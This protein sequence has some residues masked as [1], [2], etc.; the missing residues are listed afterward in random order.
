[1]T[2]DQS[3]ITFFI[4]RCLGNSVAEA[5]RN[6]GIAIEVHRDHFPD[7]TLDI[8]WIPEVARRNWVVL[9]KDSNIGKNHLERNAVARTG[10]K[11]FTL[12]SANLSGQKMSEIFLKAIVKM[13]NFVRKN[14]APFIA[15]INSKAEI[16][17][18]RDSQQLLRELN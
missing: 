14:Q 10:I 15:K 7:D 17:M 1:M 2:Q 4:D 13:Q 16:E 11:M 12:N 6:A 18:Y 8:D 3:I 9:T 5:L